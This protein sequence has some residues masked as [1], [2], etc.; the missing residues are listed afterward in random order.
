[1]KQLKSWIFSL[2]FI[3]ILLPSL[4]CS[5]STMESGTGTGSETTNGVTATVHYQDGSPAAFATVKI[6]P[7]DFLRDTV[8]AVEKK[9]EMVDTVTDTEGKISLGSLDSGEY[10]LEI[11]DSRRA[12]GALLH[13]K[14][15][16]DSLVNCGI[17]FLDQLNSITGS[18]DYSELPES[19]NVYVQIYGLDLIKKVDSSGIFDIDSLAPGSYSIRVITSQPAYIQKIITDVKVSP[20]KKAVVDKISLPL[21]SSWNYSK[22]IILNTSV[23]GANIA[24]NIYKFP[25]LIRLTKDNFDFKKAEIN[26]KDIRF[27]KKDNTPLAFEIE[28]WDHEK[29][30][31]DIW[32]KVDTI[33]GHNDSQHI[34]MLWG[35]PNATSTEN[36]GNV[37]DTAAGFQGVWHMDSSGDTE[38][39]DA[40]NN[41]YNA[42]C[43]SM[44][45]RISTV[46]GIVGNAQKFDGKTNYAIIK[47]S[48]N[49]KL[50]FSQYDFYTISAWVYSDTLNYSYQ[51]IITKGDLQYGLQLSYENKYQFFEY[52]HKRG[53]KCTESPAIGKKWKY[54]V[55]V[56]NRTEQLLY[57]DGTLVSNTY[58]VVPG[59]EIRDISENVCI[60]KGTADLKRWFTGLVDEIRI[61]NSAI[62]SNWI[63]LCYMNQ[64]S[65]D[66]F[67]IIQ[68]EHNEPK[69]LDENEQT[70]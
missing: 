32:V 7:A 70:Q 31:A 20:V 30:R 27:I 15:R 67:V 16:K 12:E 36:S 49:S 58:F 17:V 22:Q 13:C 40:T 33:L 3:S 46:E 57:V 64:R 21:K 34:F 62:N 11:K 50:N 43:Y 59:S 6:R 24:Q 47:N 41:H 51:S 66:K 4:N 26:G 48:S 29:E 69:V 63:K 8:K 19:T 37:F 44:N 25:V 54:V 60:G 52:V 56:Q 2:L 45:T 1:M 10:V 18:V 14:I 61:Y 5:V 23:T 55:A 39:L 38:L 9:N 35:N 53:W 68:E 42:K 65:D 28:R